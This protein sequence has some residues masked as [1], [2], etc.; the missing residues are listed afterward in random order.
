M[1]PGASGTDGGTYRITGSIDGAVRLGVLRRAAGLRAAVVVFGAAGLRAAGLRAAGL[2]AAGLRAAG[3][4]AAGLR[5]AARLVAG[6]RAVA[7]AAGRVVTL[8]ASCETCLLRPSSRFMTRSR[9][10]CLAAL[11]T[12]VR[13]SLTAVSKRF[14]PSLIDRSICFRTS[15]GSRFS[16]DRSADRPAFTARF[17]REREAARFLVAMVTS[18][19]WEP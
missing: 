7:P 17:S 3:L 19:C 16:A 11:L 18:W 5:A 9:S 8:R 6:R 12:R 2:R 14:C 4:R 10:A 1:G 13:T 15:G